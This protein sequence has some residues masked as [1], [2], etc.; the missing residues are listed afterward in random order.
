MFSSI[1]KPHFGLVRIPI[2]QCK[3][4]CTKIRYDLQALCKSCID[5]LSMCKC[6]VGLACE[7]NVATRGGGGVAVRS[8]PSGFF[9]NVL[10]ASAAIGVLTR[11]CRC[12]RSGCGRWRRASHRHVGSMPL[13]EPRNQQLIIRSVVD[14]Q[15]SRSQ[16][17]VDDQLGAA[18]IYPQGRGNALLFVELPRARRGLC[19]ASLAAMLA[20]GSCSLQAKIGC[21]LPGYEDD[22]LHGEAGAGPVGVRRESASSPTARARRPAL[23]A[24]GASRWSPIVGGGTGNKP[25]QRGRVRAVRP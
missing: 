6:D 15:N 19:R 21:R 14:N 18:A 8:A 12:A 5:A 9:E 4:N 2:L 20:S 22:K 16:R 17:L 25:G 24:V 13:Q 3:N 10:D 23:R 7:I 1:V 11:S